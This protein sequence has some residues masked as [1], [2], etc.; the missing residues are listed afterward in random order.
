MFW[1]TFCREITI[2]ISLTL[3]SNTEQVRNEVINLI[4]VQF[5][6]K[7]NTGVGTERCYSGNKSYKLKVTIEH[8]RDFGGTKI[9]V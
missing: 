1:C 6:K 8:F 2:G 7:M 3:A 9:L 4:G 5:N